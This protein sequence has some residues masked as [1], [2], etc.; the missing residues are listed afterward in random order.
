MHAPNTSTDERTPLVRYRALASLGNDL[1]A[2][3]R[4]IGSRANAYSLQGERVTV[5][6]SR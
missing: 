6:P 5:T 2:L 4:S 3:L 1:M